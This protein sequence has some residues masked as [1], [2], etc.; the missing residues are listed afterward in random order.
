MAPVEKHTGDD[1]F[2]G[3]VV[4][5]GE[6]TAVVTAT[7]EKTFLSKTGKLKDKDDGKSH[8]DQAILKINNY[9]IMLAIL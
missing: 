8:F 9:L 6:M 2:C 1:V 7:G 3:S 4:L 5:R